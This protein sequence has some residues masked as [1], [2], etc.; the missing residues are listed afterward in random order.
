MKRIKST[1]SWILILILIILGFSNNV[2]TESDPDAYYYHNNHHHG[3]NPKP[4]VDLDSDPCFAI[5]WMNQWDR[6]S[7]EQSAMY[8]KLKENP[9]LLEH[10]QDNNHGPSQS[11][12]G[13]VGSMHSQGKSGLRILDLIWI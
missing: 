12:Y 4:D 13:S 9:E 1:K 7:W 3:A 6:Q 5:N 2:M 8:Q 11:G 10:F